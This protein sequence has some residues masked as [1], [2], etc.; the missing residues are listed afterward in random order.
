MQAAIARLDQ[1]GIVRRR[2]VVD[3]RNVSPGDVFAAF[4]G[5]SVDG[6]DFIARAVQAGAVAVLAEAGRGSEISCSIP[7]IAVENLSRA[8][9]LIADEFYG[10]PSASVPVF[11]VT[12]TNGKT[13][14]ATWLAQ[15][16]N[17]LDRRCGFIGTLGSGFLG[18]LHESGNTTPDAATVHD[19]IAS[20]RT[21]GAKAVAM[22]VSS[23]AL[24]QARVAGVRFECAVFSN[25]TQD[26]LDY[27]KTMA[28]YGEAKTRLFTDYPV[29]HRIINVDDAFG[30]QLAAR[31][32]P[33][34]VTYGLNSGLV[35]GR[36]AAVDRDATQLVVASPW[37]EVSARVTT[38]GTFNAYN[39]TAV[40][41]A[42]LALGWDRDAVCRA[43]ESLRPA[44]GRLQR[45]DV[46]ARGMPSVFVD[47]AHT[48]DA[49]EKAI[50][51][52]GET[53][54]GKLWVV[55]GCGGNRDR[56]K[57]PM[58]GAIAAKNA[59]QVI[60]TSDNPRNER[61]SAII[62]DIIDGIDSS[63]NANVQI[64]TDRKRAIFDAV[65]HAAADDS[66]LVAGKGH[67]NYQEIA[68]VREHF[69]DVEEV[70]QALMARALQ[71][72]A[73]SVTH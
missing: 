61:P 9:G 28:A 66:I 53:C 50:G 67:E 30:L 29:R 37:G 44:D 18:A 2:L 23:H 8:I 31:R 59:Q 51:A 69:S 73:T 21:Q 62:Q 13:T 24:D 70:K 40:V 6:R 34:T 48:P 27:H 19:A 17:T 56:T 4:P 7:V 45:V 33:N 12:G 5:A 25:L 43:I 38:T 16:H 47:Y 49:L 63:A 58:M 3:S 55:F 57:R 71:R 72:E 52:V 26:H 54:R 22:E 65:L 36:I 14:I 35:R 68:G 60:I 32:L 42:L 20:M 1:L 10:Q 39:A 64:E 15:A 11:A 46:N 41:A